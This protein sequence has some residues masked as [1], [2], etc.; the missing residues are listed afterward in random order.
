MIYHLQLQDWRKTAMPTFNVEVIHEPTGKY[1][2]FT[3][4][5]ENYDEDNPITEDDAW[6]Y[7]MDELS[8]VCQQVD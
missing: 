2:N 5:L 4:D 1:M 7:I 6:Q 8:I 3:A